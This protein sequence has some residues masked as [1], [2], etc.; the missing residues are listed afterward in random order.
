MPVVDAVLIEASFPDEL[1]EVAS[2]SHHL[3]PAALRRELKKLRHHAADILA[4]HIKPAYR[5]T[6]VQQL[7]DLKIPKLQIMEPGKDYEW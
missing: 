6:V 4:V 1:Q 7:K 2:V 5:S 3:T